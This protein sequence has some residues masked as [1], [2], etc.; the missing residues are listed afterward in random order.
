LFASDANNCGASQWA[1]KFG[2]CGDFFPCKELD[3][4]HRNIR[5]FLRLMVNV[6]VLV[7]YELST[8]S[9]GGPASETQ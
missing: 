9:G 2:L 5:F 8:S 6:E 4:I 7:S 3:V 1:V